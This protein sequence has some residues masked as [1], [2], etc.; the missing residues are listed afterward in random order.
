MKKILYF[1]LIFIITG[2]CSFDNKTGIWNN[3]NQKPTANPIDIGKLEKN[4]EYVKKCKRG[5]FSLKRNNKCKNEEFINKNLINVFPKDKIYTEEKQISLNEKLKINSPLKNNNWSEQYLSST[6]NIAN[7]YYTNKQELVYKSSRLSKNS[8]DVSPLFYNNNLVSYDHKGT[9]FIYSLAEDRKI[10]EYNFYNKEFKKYKKKL[11]LTIDNDVI[12]VADNLGFVYSI[13]IKTNKVIWAKNFGV[14]F[15]SNIKILNNNLYLANEE[16]QLYAINIINGNT[17]WTFSTQVSILRSGF[18]NNILI[19]EKNNNVILLNTS[20]ELY[21]INYLNKNINWIINFNSSS[22]VNEN[23][24]F[25]SFPLILNNN[26]LITSN[27]SSLAG[28]DVITKKKMWEKKLIIDT[29]ATITENN[30]FVYTAENFLI[31][32]DVINGNII[33][34]KDLF[35]QIKLVNKK[36]TSKKI[37]NIVSQTIADNEILLFSDKGYLI[38]FDFKNGKLNSVKKI[39]KSGIKGRPIIVEGY[40]YLFDK[41]NKLLQFN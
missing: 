38:T 24:I 6:N 2:N 29:K 8:N 21:S 35:N 31:C 25:N 3:E 32:L 36:Y 33:W 28:Y 27:G 22:Q 40:I 41:K 10:L 18:K 11:Y 14:P 17:N 26:K 13:K 16:N 30:V 12:Y 20:A 1:L 7:L 15:R 39:V 34:A 37:G 9:I 5:I 19:D 23:E 4:E